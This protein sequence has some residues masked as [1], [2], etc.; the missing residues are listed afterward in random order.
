ME[1]TQDSRAVALA[2]DLMFGARIRAAANTAG[3]PLTLVRSAAELQQQAAGARLV[4]IDLDARG[5]DVPAA[6]AAL[7]ADARTAAATVVVFGPHV[8]G[9]ALQAARRAG[10]DVVLARSAFVGRLP[11]LMRRARQGTVTEQGAA[12]EPVDD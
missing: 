12:D 10:A 7:R 2:P 1:H 5:V 8:D 11:D 3:V 6:V 4:L 9:A